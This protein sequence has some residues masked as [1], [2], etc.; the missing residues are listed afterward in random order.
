MPIETFRWGMTL[1]A[2]ELDF[3]GL[4]WC[5]LDEAK[6]FGYREVASRLGQFHAPTIAESPEG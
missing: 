5:R 4:P 2:C 1:G 6:V 3:D